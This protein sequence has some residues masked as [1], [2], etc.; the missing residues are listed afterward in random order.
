MARRTTSLVDSILNDL[1]DARDGIDSPEA[2]EFPNN[3]QAML[4]ER[5]VI[6][7]DSFIDM[8]IRGSIFR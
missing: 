4:E 6:K 1:D 7:D 2:V 3:V 5:P 8:I